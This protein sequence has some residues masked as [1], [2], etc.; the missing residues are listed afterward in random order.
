MKLT[1]SLLFLFAFALFQTG[2]C[3][4]FPC[5]A[6]TGPNLANNGDNSEVDST[7]NDEF[8]E[9]GG[10]AGLL[11]RRA[12][13]VKIDFDPVERKAPGTEAEALAAIDDI[14][15]LYDSTNVPDAINGSTG[16][17]TRELSAEVARAVVL[18]QKQLPLDVA[19][20]KGLD[21]KSIAGDNASGAQQIDI[22]RNAA[23][24]RLEDYLPKELEF[25]IDNSKNYFT[26]SLKPIHLGFVTKAA[27]VDMNDQLAVTNLLS[28]ETTN[29][30]REENI[31][32]LAE[33][34]EAAIVFDETLGESPSPWR[35]KRDDFGLIVIRYVDKLKQAADA[36]Q[37]PKDIGNDELTKIAEEVMNRG[38]N[39]VPKPERVIVNAPKK[40]LSKD[41]FTVDF[42]DRTIAKDPYR[43][44]QFQCAT[45]EKEG[46]G[47][48]LW[49]NVLKK[50]S[51]G[52]HTVPTNKWI[53]GERF[54][55]APISEKNINN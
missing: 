11:P 23:L 40:S 27:D 13:P 20:L 4:C 12:A 50:Y 31:R 44:E 41:H 35:K 52:P 36:I 9:L 25:T 17:V 46:D 10:D 15:K 6:S 55:S 8:E 3:C 5:G 53:I 43:W 32:M 7:D 39:G 16:A 51:V 45:I 33:L 38:A 14:R 47:Y 18:L 2:C 54:R 26:E 28:S 34:Y 21:G 1:C 30:A 48:A 42:S 19:Y 22:A 29:R 24:S 49:Y 37:P